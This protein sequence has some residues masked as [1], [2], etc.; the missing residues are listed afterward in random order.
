MI[1][2][3]LMAELTQL[4]KELE[5]NVRGLDLRTNQ[6]NDSVAGNQFD[7]S[8]LERIEKKIDN[9]HAHT[10]TLMAKLRDDVAQTLAELRRELS[11]RMA[12]I[13][14]E[15]GSSGVIPSDQRN[16]PLSGRAEVVK[17]LSPQERRLFELC[18]QSGPLTYRGLGE[19][20]GVSPVSA[21]NL[22]NRIFLDKDKRDLFRKER[23]DGIARVSIS[24]AVEREILKGRDS[25]EE[26][27]DHT[28]NAE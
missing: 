4:A 28:Q 13:P 6:S 12:Q 26:N 20:L 16:P 9:I 10:S 7:D 11:G 19:H 23:V 5:E 8:R 14:I 24:T 15:Q 1:M 17:N 25:S 3:R 21:K 2:Q 22:V 27:Q 18:F